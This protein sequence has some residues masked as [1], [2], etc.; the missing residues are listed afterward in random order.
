[1]ENTV[2]LRLIVG[3]CIAFIVSLVVLGGNQTDRKSSHPIVP[4]MVLFYFLLV[5]YIIL[6][7][8]PVVPHVFASILKALFP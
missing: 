8:L 1:V 6:T 7:N 4:V 3:V 2:W 5:A